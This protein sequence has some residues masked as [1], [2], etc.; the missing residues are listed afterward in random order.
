MILKTSTTPNQSTTPSMQRQMLTF[1]TLCISLTGHYNTFSDVSFISNIFMIINN[2]DA[3]GSKQTVQL[4]K[5]HVL[6]RTK[7]IR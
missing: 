5:I 6:T 3:K 7:T 1:N 2:T 4:I